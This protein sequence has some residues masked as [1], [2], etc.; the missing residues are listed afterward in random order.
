M[1]KRAGVL[2]LVLLGAWGTANA[3]AQNSFA[4]SNTNLLR[5]Q[6]VEVSGRTMPLRGSGEVSLGSFPE[7][8]IF[9]FEPNTNSARLPIR[10]RYKLEGYET[11][12]HEGDGEMYL[13]VRFYDDHGD[14]VTQA[15]SKMSGESAGGNG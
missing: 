3:F 2:S 10:L 5:I 6:S 7:N 4:A 13:G 9:H 14:Q 1:I 11:A 8:I 15:T 12:W